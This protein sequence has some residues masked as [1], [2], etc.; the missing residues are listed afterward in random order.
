M[1]WNE[2][3][4]L[5]MYHAYKLG[6]LEN[7][8]ASNWYKSEIGFFDFYVIPLAKK[9]E[10]CGV[11]GVSSDEFLIYAKENREEWVRRGEDLVQLFGEIQRFLYG[12]EQLSFSKQSSLV[13]LRTVVALEGLGRGLGLIIG[14][15]CFSRF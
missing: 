6:R 11:F 5:E 4:F 7:D 3:L 1:G 13:M 15:E 8:P 14:I 12:N 2:K 10:T 9:L